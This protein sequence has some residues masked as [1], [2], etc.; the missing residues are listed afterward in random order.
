MKAV[1][2]SGVARLTIG[3]D[4]KAAMNSPPMNALVRWTRR[5]ALACGTGRNRMATSSK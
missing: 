2:N 4:T 5:N 1:P 3:I